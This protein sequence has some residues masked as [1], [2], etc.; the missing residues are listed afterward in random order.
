MSCQHNAGQ[1]QHKIVSHII[2]KYGKIY[3]FWNNSDKSNLH[4]Q[5]NVRA[6]DIHG[7]HANTP[8][9]STFLSAN[10][11]AQGNNFSSC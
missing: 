7:T 6:D 2:Q 4:S 5:S 8:V 11:S 9:I 3:I 10:Y 1:T